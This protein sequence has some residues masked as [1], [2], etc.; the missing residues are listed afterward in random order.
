MN[1]T[2]GSERTTNEKIAVR[3]NW[4]KIF[5]VV[6]VIVVLSIK[7]W[8]ADFS[9]AFAAFK[10][11][12]LL[13]L[14][15][16]LFA[17]A[18][19]VLFYLKATDTSNIFYDNTYRFTRDVS[20]ILGRVEAGFGEKLAHLDEGYSGLKT[21]VERIPFDRKQTEKDIEEEEQQLQKVEKERAELIENLAERARLEGE[22][23]D[24]LFE[25]LQKQD[26]ELTS[27]RREIA[28]LRHRMI[29]AEGQIDDNGPS[30]L[31]SSFRRYLTRLISGQIPKDM[32][33]DAPMGVLSENFK[34]ILLHGDHP[35]AFL[36]DIRR[37]GIVDEENYLTRR[38]RELLR[39][40]LLDRDA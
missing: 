1:K 19:S 17:I 29:E 25:R 11:S 4:L 8:Q 21:A 10:F 31:S 22:E 12:D 34:D 7:L 18:L 3:N 27:A 28:F 20:E 13:A 14:F 39:K 15:L 35:K 36:R 30:A 38:G 24:R 37:Y 33:I 6:V 23:K 40:L 2:S 9:Q 16:A 26:E 5:V 32:L